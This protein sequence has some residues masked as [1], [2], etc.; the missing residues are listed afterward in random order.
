M[1]YMVILTSQEEK[2]GKRRANYAVAERSEG[3]GKK[4]KRENKN[5]RCMSP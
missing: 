5:L 3:K 1:G 2:G 4:K